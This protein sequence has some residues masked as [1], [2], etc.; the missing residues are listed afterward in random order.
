MPNCS[1]SSSG[2]I[3][4]TSWPRARMSRVIQWWKA[5]W[6]TTALE[7]MIFIGRSGMIADWG[8][9]QQLLWRLGRFGM[10]ELLGLLLLMGALSVGAAPKVT[11]VRCPDGGVQPQAAVDSL[12]KV[13]LIYLK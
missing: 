1:Q 2:S 9:R 12:G 13:H 8:W 10:R 5:P 6:A 3:R 11:L 4:A 7:R